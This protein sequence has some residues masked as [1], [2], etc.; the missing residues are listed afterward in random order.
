MTNI[1]LYWMTLQIAC[2]PW[3]ND[4]DN[5][6]EASNDCDDSDPNVHPYALEICDGIDNNCD[7][8]ID[9]SHFQVLERGMQTSIEMDMEMMDSPLSPVNSLRGMPPTN[10]TATS[11]MSLSIL[12]Q[13]R[14][15]TASITT[16]MEKS[17][18]ALPQMP[19]P[20]IQIMMGMVL[21]IQT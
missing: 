19:M 9:D 15:V 17:M 11:P 16:A 12:A 10:G 1:F 5:F 20:G 2:G 18:R 6:D 14:S 4:G 21:A 3:D 7:G 8:L 13:K